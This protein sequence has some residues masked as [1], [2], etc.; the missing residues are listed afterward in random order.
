[1]DTI[2]MEPQ[3]QTTDEQLGSPGFTF[4]LGW[5]AGVV[6][7]ALAIATVVRRRARRDRDA[8]ADT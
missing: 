1:M 6:L 3:S 2:D 7:G 5:L 4:E 8:I